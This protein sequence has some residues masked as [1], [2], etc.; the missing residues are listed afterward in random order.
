MIETQS[1]LRF[2]P[3][4]LLFNIN[5]V[6]YNNCQGGVNMSVLRCSQIAD[7]LINSFAHLLCHL[8]LENYPLVFSWQQFLVL[9]PR[10]DDSVSVMKAWYIIVTFFLTNWDKCLQYYGILVFGLYKL[11]T[12]DKPQVLYIFFNLI[13]Q[14]SR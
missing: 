3:S 4:E 6:I 2:C 14:A 10:D 8:F 1:H 12:I 5:S 13:S 9:V 7:M 11:F